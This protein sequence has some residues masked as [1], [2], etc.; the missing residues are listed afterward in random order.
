MLRKNR[1]LCVSYSIVWLI[2]NNLDFFFLFSLFS[3]S[4]ECEPATKQQKWLWFESILRCVKW[5]FRKFSIQTPWIEWKW[6][7][8]EEK[9][10]EEPEWNPRMPM[11][12]IHWIVYKIYMRAFEVE[13]TMDNMDLFAIV[14]CIGMGMGLRMGM[15]ILFDSVSVVVCMC[16]CFNIQWVTRNTYLLEN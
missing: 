4:P 12:R 15:G 9:K 2:V 13:L 1:M 10:N 6:T 7:K 3:D 11:I 5:T 16:V 8:R 14:V